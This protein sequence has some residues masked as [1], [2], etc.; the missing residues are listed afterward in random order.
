MTNGSM[1]TLAKYSACVVKLA[2]LHPN[3]SFP[4]MRLVMSLIAEGV[5][6]HEDKLIASEAAE[7]SELAIRTVVLGSTV[8]GWWC[9]IDDGVA[10]KGERGFYMALHREC[11]ER[12]EV[13]VEEA[14]C[15]YHDMMNGGG[16][17]TEWAHHVA[18]TALTPRGHYMLR[19]KLAN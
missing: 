10:A 16:E 8:G 13:L 12:E 19:R 1:I 6:E 15:T 4:K 11:R 14:V 2:E 5:E 18:Y 3:A 17:Q 7:N 9:S